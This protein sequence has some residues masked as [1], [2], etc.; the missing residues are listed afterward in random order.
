MNA[1]GKLRL[2]PM[3]ELLL[4]DSSDGRA[5]MP[6]QSAAVLRWLEAAR[7]DTARQLMLWMLYGAELTE[8]CVLLELDAAS[9]AATPVREVPSCLTTWLNSD[10]M[11]TAVAEL[12]AAVW[13]AEVAKA[14]SASAAASASASASAAVAAAALPPARVTW[15]RERHAALV[16]EFTEG[17]LWALAVPRASYQGMTLP[18]GAVV[19]N[20]A[21]FATD[22]TRGVCPPTATVV[23]CRMALTAVHEFGHYARVRVMGP[24]TRTPPMALPASAPQRPGPDLTPKP[25]AG[26]AMERALV[27]GGTACDLPALWPDTEADAAR[28]LA[29]GGV[30]AFPHA[31][32]RD[33]DGS[34]PGGA[35]PSPRRRVTIVT[36]APTPAMSDEDGGE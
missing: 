1:R 29:W 34:T 36:P 13:E 24:K 21:S 7:D 8:V 31:Q 25:E 17:A 16:R 28:M 20:T 15:T 35:R 10:A 2:R 14:Q 5:G 30:G 18:C 9:A 32:Q 26:L 27:Q 19:L 12:L 22:F 4:S 3:V 11:V 33:S 23:Q 6:K